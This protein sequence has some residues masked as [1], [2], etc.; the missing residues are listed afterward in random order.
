MRKSAV[1]RYTSA[2]LLASL[3]LAGPGQTVA[4]HDVPDLHRASY[5]LGIPLMPGRVNISIAFIQFGADIAASSKAGLIFTSN[6]QN[7]TIDPA[8]GHGPTGITIE[9][10]KKVLKG[11][12]EKGSNKSVVTVDTIGQFTI[13]MMTRKTAVISGAFPFQIYLTWLD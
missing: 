4:N 10:D 7:V 12:F 9:L 11:S 5:V 3:C 8:I 13:T 1:L 2:I 6:Y